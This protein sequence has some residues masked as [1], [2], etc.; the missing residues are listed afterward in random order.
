MVGIN[1]Y[2]DRLGYTHCRRC[3]ADRH[4]RFRV[5]YVGRMSI[6]E[7]LI[8]GGISLF[9]GALGGILTAGVITRRSE[10]AKTYIGPRARCTKRCETTAITCCMSI[11][12]MASARRISERRLLKVGSSS[13][14]VCCDSCPP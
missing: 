14:P 10:S 1:V 9:A 12:R 2:T 3:W 7:V 13:P 6:W 11:A 5:G 8:S 4:H